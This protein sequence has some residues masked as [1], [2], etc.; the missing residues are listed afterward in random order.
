MRDTLPALPREIELA[1][2]AARIR[3]RLSQASSPLWSGAT[4]AAP[5][6]G[7]T[8]TLWRALAAAERERQLA[9]GLEAAGVALDQEAHGLAIA[10]RRTGRPREARVS[11]LLVLADDGAERFYRQAER[12]ARRH[13]ERLLVCVVAA[14]AAELGRAALGRPGR[15]KAL[16]VRHKQAVAAVLRAVGAEG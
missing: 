14:G 11:R 10:D 12:I 8:R 15:V 6:L 13:A 3:A 1:P 5:R 7:A 16:L 9:I 4:L 2:E